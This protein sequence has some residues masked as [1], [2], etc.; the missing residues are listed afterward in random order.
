MIKYFMKK[1][2]ISESG[3]KNLMKGGINSAVLD[4][5]KIAPVIMAFM[6]LDEFLNPFLSTGVMPTGSIQ[7]Y[8]VVGIG[9]CIVFY[10]V[11]LKAYNSTYVAIYSESKNTRINLAETLRKLPLSFFAKRDVADLAATIM[12][13]VTIIEQLFS[14]NMPQLIGS[15][16]S[17]ALFVIMML[18]YN[19]KLTLSLI[20]VVPIAILCFALALNWMKR[21]SKEL[22]NIQISIH[23]E[24]QECLDGV[25]EIKAYNREEDFSKKVDKK[26]DKYE[27]RLGQLELWGGC[28]V[29]ASSVILKLALITVTFVGIHLVAQG[30]ATLFELIVYIIIAGRIFD[31]ILLVLTNLALMLVINART[32]RLAGVLDVKQQT[33]RED[34]NPNN[35]DIE[36]KDVKFAYEEDKETIKDVSFTAKQGEVTALIGPSGGGKSTIAKLAARFWDIQDGK[37][38]IGGEDIS[39]IDPE[40]LLKHFSIV[41]QDVTLF[42][43]SILENIRVGK[44]DATDEEVLAVAKLA[45]CDEFV[46]KLADGYNTQ[47]GENGARLSGGERQR[48]SIARAMLKDA[49]II[50]LDEATASLDVENESKIQKALSRLIEDKTV[51][52]IAHRMRTV[53]NADKLVV[54]SDGKIVESGVPEELLSHDSFLSKMSKKQS[55]AV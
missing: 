16:I 11:A 32:E 1:F 53:K 38:T 47:V 2:R 34:F 3:A 37:I 39:E 36:F 15:I 5:I 45:E 26:L 33:G 10:L 17:T 30:E 46:N 25:Y 21:G 52:I 8:V 9:I 4:I 42:D 43:N 27:K 6:F 29:N 44:K 13:D 23:N 24:V 28:I 31:S 22:T 40:A 7:K 12:S 49:E 55:M 48:I 50:L 51:V 54:I 19:F 20:V 14:H 35:F 18:V 41:F